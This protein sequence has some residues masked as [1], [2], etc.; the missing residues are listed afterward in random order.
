MPLLVFSNGCHSGQFTGSQDSVFGPAHAFLMAGVRHYIGTFWELV[1]GQGAQ[2]AR[3]FYLDLSRGATVGAAVRNA[4]NRVIAESGEAEL[5][6]AAY[7]LYGDPEHAPIQKQESREGWSDA[8]MALKLGVRATA[9]YKP[10]SRKPSNEDPPAGTP[11]QHA[12]EKRNWSTVILSLLALFTLSMVVLLGL[13][14]KRIETMAPKAASAAKTQGRNA[15]RPAPGPN[16]A[17]R[18]AAEKTADARPSA[19]IHVSKVAISLTPGPSGDREA[20]DAGALL[21]SCLTEKIAPTYQVIQASHGNKANTARIL[22]S[23]HRLHGRLFITV[24]ATVGGT[25]LNTQILEMDKGLAPACGQA[26]QGIVAHL[27][28]TTAPQTPGAS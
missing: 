4:R 8:D 26:A 25:I 14:Y 13:L 3:H 1:D 11:P 12:S 18:H 9:P 22:V 15:S 19:P 10:K 6:W 5:A 17:A 2:F 27:K 23:P 16:Q 20:N 7:V 24:T 28:K 21:A